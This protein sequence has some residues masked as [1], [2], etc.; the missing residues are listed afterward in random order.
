[1]L[2]WNKL[3]GN[4][5]RCETVKIKDSKDSFIII[6]KEDFDK[7]KHVLFKEKPAKKNQEEKASD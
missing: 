7:G 2:Q 5:M 1:M 4:I 3:M 6:N